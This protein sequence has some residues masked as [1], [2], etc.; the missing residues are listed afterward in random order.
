MVERFSM[1]YGHQLATRWDGCGCELENH[2]DGDLGKGGEAGVWNPDGFGGVLESELAD[3]EEYFCDLSTRYSTSLHHARRSEGS[4]CGFCTTGIAVVRFWIDG[5]GA[6]RYCMTFSLGSVG[7]LVVLG[8]G[9]W[10]VDDENGRWDM[11]CDSV[12]AVAPPV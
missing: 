6:M 2:R 5:M 7:G 11:F 3:W 12:S 4:C 10:G 1:P 9:G 8:R